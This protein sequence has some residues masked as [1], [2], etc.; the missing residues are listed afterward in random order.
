MRLLISGSRNHPNADIV[1]EVLD[2]L[3]ARGPISVIVHGDC[4]GDN[5][6]DYRAKAWAI[7]N[8][9]EH[10]P[11]PA[12]WARGRRAGPERN[13]RMV[14]LGADRVVALPHGES[15]GTR[16]LIGFAR[17]AELPVTVLDSDGNPIER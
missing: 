15:R 8:N 7:A 11:H 14:E 3:H 5:S 13:Q 10:E 9:V 6:V 2:D 16:S 4:P 12:N 1:H 17:Q